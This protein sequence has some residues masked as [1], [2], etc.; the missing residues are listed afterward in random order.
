[1]GW[2]LNPLRIFGWWFASILVWQS[3][4]PALRLLDALFVRSAVI[5]RSIRSNRGLVFV[6]NGCVMRRRNV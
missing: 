3:H 1:M 6:V 4:F 5:H 2:A